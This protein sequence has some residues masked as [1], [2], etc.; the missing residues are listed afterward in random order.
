M[1]P[2]RARI[3][4]FV[5]VPTGGQWTGFRFAVADYAARDQIRIVE[6]GS[7]GVHQGVAELAT[8]VNR[9]GGFRER[10]GWGCRREKKIA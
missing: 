3:Q 9:S 7:V 6:H 2:S 10:R 5:G 8:F 1:A 4:E